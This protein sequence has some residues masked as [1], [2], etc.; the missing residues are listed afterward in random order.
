MLIPAAWENNPQFSNEEKAFYQYHAFLTEPWDGPAAIVASDGLDITAGLDRSG[1]RPMRWM[2]S[3]RYVLAASE[4]GICPSVEAGAYKTAQLEPGQTIMYRVNED[5]LLDER[6]VIE[7][8]SK[9][10]PYSKWVR[11]EPLV[12]NDEY[13]ELPD[14]IIDIQK[15]SHLYNYT[16]E[17]ERLILLPM[18][19]VS[20]THLTLPTICSV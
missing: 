11:T 14:N 3:D 20:Y 5:E 16:S 4:V 6:Q 9:K 15:L 1:L 2:V 13:N 18:I 17:E 7:G 8:L 12:I 19:P 10:N